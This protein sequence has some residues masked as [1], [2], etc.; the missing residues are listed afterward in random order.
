MVCVVRRKCDEREGYLLSLLCAELLSRAGFCPEL[1]YPCNLI[2]SVFLMHKSKTLR[3]EQEYDE[4]VK[5]QDLWEPHH[6]ESVS[7]ERMIQM[8]HASGVTG[9]NVI[10]HFDAEGVQLKSKGSNIQRQNIHRV[11]RE[12]SRALVKRCLTSF[13]SKRPSVS[14][15]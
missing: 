1:K 10:R 7:M 2:W 8:R 6:L 4:K 3:P 11:A 12:V 13:R 15:T 5:E 14:T 9:W